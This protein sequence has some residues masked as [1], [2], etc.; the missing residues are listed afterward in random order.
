MAIS[1]AVHM[2]NT[3][4]QKERTGMVYGCVEWDPVF[5]GTVSRED[6]L[7]KRDE[8][9]LAFQTHDLQVGLQP[10]LYCVVL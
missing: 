10:L 3:S 4:G 6:L 7:S 2:T 5:D 9:K 8:L 1:L